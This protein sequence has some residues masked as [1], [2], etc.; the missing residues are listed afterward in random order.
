[1]HLAADQGHVKVV[2][3][4]LKRNREAV[5]DD[6]ENANTALHLAA[7]S[8]RTNCIKELVRFGANISAR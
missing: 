6:D 2:I 7:L 1:M 8:G 5:H 3:E 4:I